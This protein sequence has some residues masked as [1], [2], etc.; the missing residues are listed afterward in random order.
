MKM[1]GWQDPAIIA[2]VLAGL[3]QSIVAIRDWRQGH[4]QRQERTEERYTVRLERTIE[5]LE[6]DLAHER[7]YVS[8]LQ[9]ELVDAE[10][11]IPRR[12]PKQSG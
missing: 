10:R 1:G 11:K 7:E 4:A 9:G 3:A 6:R 12:P 5:R 2:L 8:V